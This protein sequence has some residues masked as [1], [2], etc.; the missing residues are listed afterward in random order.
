MVSTTLQHGIIMAVAW[1][2]C[3]PIGMFIAR[4]FTP[5]LHWLK[6]HIA[7]Q[8]CALVLTI[9][10]FALAVYLVYSEGSKHFSAEFNHGSLGLFILIGIIFQYVI[11]LLRPK[12]VASPYPYTNK[13]T[14]TYNTDKIKPVKRKVFEI[15]HRAL[16]IALLII[17]YWNVHT[18]IK[19]A[20][21]EIN[22]NLWQK[23]LL[24]FIVGTAVIVFSSDMYNI[25]F[26][27][28]VV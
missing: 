4:Y 1:V 6:F 5:A 17:A 3:I 26:R 19:L 10:G 9:A 14:L 24:G 18:G 22:A 20:S 25:Y 23:V 8:T 11:G 15:Q 13:N 28:Q 2:V 21:D 7:F 16:A 27:K 12:Y